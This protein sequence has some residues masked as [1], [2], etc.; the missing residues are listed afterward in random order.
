MTSTR[1]WREL[2]AC[3]RED[4]ELFFG[5]KDSPVG[6]SPFARELKAIAVCNRCSVVANCLN[7]AMAAGEVKHGV[8]GGLRA[9]DR[10]ALR[11]SDRQA[12]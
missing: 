1:E 8:I 9:A 7:W 3:R 5:I 2:A 10:V 11:R 6:A 12:A 4:P